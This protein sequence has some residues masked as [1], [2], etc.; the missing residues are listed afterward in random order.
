[1]VL[2]CQVSPAVGLE[3]ALA[4]SSLCV[5]SLVMVCLFTG[6]LL[7][8][9]R[10]FVMPTTATKPVKLLDVVPRCATFSS[11]WYLLPLLVFYIRRPVPEFQI[12]APCHR[13]PAVGQRGRRRIKWKRI[14]RRTQSQVSCGGIVSTGPGK[15]PICSSSSTLKCAIKLA[16][17]GICS[18]VSTGDGKLLRSLSYNGVGGAMGVPP[19]ELPSETPVCFAAAGA[20][21][22]RRP[23]PD[24]L[25]RPGGDSQ[26][27][28]LNGNASRPDL[29]DSS[30]AENLAAEDQR[31]LRHA[32]LQPME[33]PISQEDGAMRGNDKKDVINIYDQ[34][35]SPNLTEVRRAHAMGYRLEGSLSNIAMNLRA[36]NSYYNWRSAQ[37]IGKWPNLAGYEA[38]R[39]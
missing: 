4:R 6:L 31:Q 9:L 5:S 1:M 3:L 22:P 15:L 30:L 25:S 12:A 23:H 26:H 39:A 19:E 18:H 21:D 14:R 7:Q 11:E 29:L 10:Y 32:A 8:F 28:N 33:V 36:Y 27:T 16:K 17:L 2:A 37:L 34:D 20:Q 13:W 24:V 38:M 35:Q